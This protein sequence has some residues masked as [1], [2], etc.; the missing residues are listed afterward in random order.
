VDIEGGEVDELRLL[1]VGDFRDGSYQI[2]LAWLGADREDLPGLNIG[3]EA[4]NQLG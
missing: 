3:A 4:H 1:P 2:L